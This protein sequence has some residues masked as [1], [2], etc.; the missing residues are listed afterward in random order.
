MENKE[1]KTPTNHSSIFYEEVNFLNNYN[2][3]NEL[4]TYKQSEIRIF[5]DIYS[6][7]VI[8]ITQNEIE[9][10]NKQGR[11]LK[12]V[13]KINLTIEE[14]LTCTL[15]SS[16]QYLLIAFENYIF[17]LNV[18][19]RKKEILEFPDDENFKGI[20]FYGD[21]N[22]LF[23][24]KT[25]INFMI[26]YEKK[27]YYFKIEDDKVTEIKSKKT[28]PIKSYLFNQHFLIL[29]IEL[30]GFKFNLY[31]LNSVKYYEKQN[32][33]VLPIKGRFI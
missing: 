1:Y 11:I 17:I 25:Y 31:N 2:Q 24:N 14:I 29:V 12:K 16:L 23:Q 8:R 13:I 26:I 30:H 32:Q 10:Y 3:N 28:K 6:K 18:N 7:N 22:Y 27:N 5:Y 33:F 20:F 21:T 19:N 4:I 9:I 15:D